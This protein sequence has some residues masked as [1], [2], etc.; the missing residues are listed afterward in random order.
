MRVSKCSHRIAFHG[1]VHSLHTA[2]E[3]YE[4]VTSEL[5]FNSLSNRGC[6]SV[7]LQDDNLLENIEEIG[8]SLIT[9]DEQVILTPDTAIITVIDTDGM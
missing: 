7:T 3:D 2:P 4:T 6:I 9:E 5:T 1:I 8:V